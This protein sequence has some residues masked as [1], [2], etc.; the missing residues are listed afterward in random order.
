MCPR[1][2]INHVKQIVN[3]FETEKK[4]DQLKKVIIIQKK[5]TKKLDNNSARNVDRS[6]KNYKYSS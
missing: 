4:I 1:I 6:L 5:K 3:T 2:L